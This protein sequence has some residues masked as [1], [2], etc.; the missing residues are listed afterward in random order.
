LDSGHG[1]LR[2]HALEVEQRLDLEVHDRGVLEGARD[3]E[4]ELAAVLRGEP[5]VLVPL[6]LERSESARDAKLL[7]H[8]LLK[9]RCVEDGRVETQVFERERSI[10]NHH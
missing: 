6:S 2:V 10:G 4:D 7:L 9:S 1:K 5:V 3:L 8:D